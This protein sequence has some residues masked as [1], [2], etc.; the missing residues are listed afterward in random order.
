MCRSSSCVGVPPPRFAEEGAA[1]AKD[2]V[3]LGYFNEAQPFE[4]ACARGWFEG[5]L[6]IEVVCLPQTAGVLAI[7]KLDDGDL[8]QSRPLSSAGLSSAISL[9]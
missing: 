6:D 8:D 4:V 9:F 3:R 7:S 2:V 5:D 1:T